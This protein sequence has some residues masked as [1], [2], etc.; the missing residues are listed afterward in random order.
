VKWWIEDSG[1]KT[2]AAAV[3]KEFEEKDP[4]D[5]PISDWLRIEDEVTAGEA[6]RHLGIEIGNQ[7]K[8]QQMRIA[9]LLKKLGWK[10]KQIGAD[11]RRVWMRA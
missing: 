1:L 11:R 3:R 7:T 10:N 6:L 4:W 5:K 2:A 9:G 8:A